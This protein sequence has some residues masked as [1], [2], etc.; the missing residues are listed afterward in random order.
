MTTF[1]LWNPI[2]APPLTQSSSEVVAT[3]VTTSYGTSVL[4]LRHCLTTPSPVAVK[5]ISRVARAPV[6]DWAT[7]TRVSLH[8]TLLPNDIVESCTVFAHVRPRKSGP[9]ANYRTVRISASI[10][11]YSYSFAVANQAALARVHLPACTSHSI[12]RSS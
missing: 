7:M 6:E 8:P 10:L 2:H 11:L 12:R 1:V 3:A 5:V 4:H 9:P